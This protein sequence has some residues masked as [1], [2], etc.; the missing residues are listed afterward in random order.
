MWLALQRVE[1]LL[2]NPEAD[3]DVILKAASTVATLG[4][5]Y[6]NVTKTH[7]LE[8]ELNDLQKVFNEFRATLGRP[9]ITD[10][11]SSAAQT[12]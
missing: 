12:N 9:A 2:R 8:S 1:E 10:S 11:G 6:S 4:G 7:A 3:P 5:A